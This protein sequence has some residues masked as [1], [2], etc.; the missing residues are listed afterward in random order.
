M[1][2]HENITIN[3]LLADGNDIELIQ[4]SHTPRTKSTDIFMRELVWEMKS[5][6]GKTLRPIERIVRRATR[7]SSNIIID[8]RRTPLS[9]KVLVDAIIKYFHQIRE[10]RNLWII[11]KQSEIIKF[12]K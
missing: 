9:D 10:I 7:Q 1:E 2:E 6:T 11:D 4:K 5:P 3:T 8:L 12:K